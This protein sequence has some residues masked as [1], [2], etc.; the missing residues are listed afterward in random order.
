MHAGRGARQI[1]LAGVDI[2]FNFSSIRRAEKTGIAVLQNREEAWVRS[3]EAHGYGPD[4]NRE[5]ETLDFGG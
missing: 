4:F 1:R 3:V 2:K 5:A